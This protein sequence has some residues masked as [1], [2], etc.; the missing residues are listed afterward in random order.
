MKV[1]FIVLINIIF[2]MSPV[3]AQSWS[4]TGNSISAGNYLG[5]NNFNN[6]IFKA[7]NSNAGLLD[8]NYNCTFFGLL[9]GGTAGS[10]STSNTAFGN[11]ALKLNSTGIGNTVMGYLALPQNTSGTT[12]TAIGQEAMYSNTSGSN[13][14]AVGS[15][16]LYYNTT[17]ILNC[18]FGNNSLQDNTTGSYNCGFGA[19]T[20]SSNTTGSY[21]TAAGYQ[22]AMSNTTANGNTAFGYEAL[23][24]NSTGSYNTATGNT[25]LYSNLSGSYNTAM[26]DES[27]YEN[28]SGSK[29]T[30][31]GD[32]ALFYST[33]GNQNTA[34]GGG[35]LA[36]NTADNNTA[37]GYSSATATTGTPVTGIGYESL[38]SNTTGVSNTAIGV[39][40]ISNNTTGSNNASIGPAAGPSAGNLSGTVAIGVNGTVYS[41][42]TVLVG[43]TALIGG[44]TNWFILVSDGRFK[45]NITE[46]VPGLEF[47]STLRP[48][49]Y[50]YD[51]K[52]MNDFLSR[53]KSNLNTKLDS[54][55]QKMN[56]ISKLQQDLAVDQREK[57][58]YSGF[59]AQEVDD[60]AKKIGYNFSGVVKPKNTNDIYRLG[61]S[62]FV[63]SEV[64][65][66]QQIR[67]ENDSLENY[68][69]NLQ[70]R[71][72]NIKQQIADLKAKKTNTKILPTISLSVKEEP[73][74]VSYNKEN[75]DLPKSFKKE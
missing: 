62:D 20:L 75:A 67:H 38:Y 7:N 51:I 30:A 35:A 43:S 59:I 8:L 28:T 58:I 10:S 1:F 15:L 47:L 41:S 31:I 60:A 74:D 73:S 49:S 4:L 17:G 55:F 53:G 65:A 3:L 71:I 16:S 66:V 54:N 69:N 21:N 37:A 40:A 5:T 33:T 52:G 14:T 34:V 50:T 36:N 13:N 61:Y 9:S 39:G 26:G 45:K 27:I 12:N 48:V 6:L 56:S 44:Y 23:T 46:N 42:N 57:I 64:K 19:Y 2:G 24:S 70:L 25:S 72:I 29:N 22:A 32:K 11:Q 63:P 18:A 68:I